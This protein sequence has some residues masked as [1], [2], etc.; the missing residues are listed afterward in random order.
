MYRAQIKKDSISEAGV[1]LTTFEV[2]FPRFILAEFNTHRVFSRNSAS[3]RAIPIEKQIKKIKEDLF[4]PLVFGSKQAGMQAG[5]PLEGDELAHAITEWEI[6][7][8]NAVDSAQI[9]M[10]LNVH[11]QTANRLL[12]PFMWHTVVVTAV[13]YENFFDQRVS[14]LAQPEINQIATLMQ[15][16]YNRSTPT[17]LAYGEW[18]TPYISPQEYD[19]FGLY[20]RVKV[21][22]ARC[23]RTSY[24][25][26][27]GKRDVDKDIKLYER[28]VTAEPPHYSPLEHV[29]T[30]FLDQEALGNFIDWKKHEKHYYPFGW[31]QLRHN[32]QWV[33]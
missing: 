11:K 20:T 31:S 26:Q 10:E 33:V 6:A 3:S 1:R 15:G 19:E 8:H 2:E 23:A 27:D 17:E 25:T 9:L 7:A 22:A 28:L 24:L 12:E 16:C 14:P 4:I 21:S 29:A 32:S 18:H 5:P 30:P 13:D